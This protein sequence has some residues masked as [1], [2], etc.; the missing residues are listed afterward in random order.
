MGIEVGVS[1]SIKTK[2]NIETWIN[3][4]LSREKI[5]R[6]EIPEASGQWRVD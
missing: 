5:C 1:Y 3:N 4:R 6:E 2:D